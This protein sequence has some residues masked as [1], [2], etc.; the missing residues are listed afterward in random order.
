MP[1]ELL[2]GGVL[3][4]AADVYSFG[5]L[6]WEL[7]TGE[8]PYA[9]KNHGEIIV[10]VVN[11]HDRPQL[12]DFIPAQYS[13]L[14]M[15]CWQHNHLARPGFPEIIDRI[16]QMLS[17]YGKHGN[18]RLTSVNVR[19]PRVESVEWAAP[20]QFT[21][22]GSMGDGSFRT[23]SLYCEMAGMRSPYQPQVFP[24]HG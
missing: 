7:V 18:Q 10:D 4:P 9:G 22:G 2:K 1:P 19:G 23:S 20:P 15:D 11:D 24:F 14:A 5:I 16:R 3:S 12:P 17:E 6:L 21:S 8:S 13:S